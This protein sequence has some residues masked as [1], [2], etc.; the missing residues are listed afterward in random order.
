MFYAL[1]GYAPLRS[2]PIA[3]AVGAAGWTVYGLLTLFTEV[4]PVTATGIAARRRRCRGR[5]AAPRRE[6]PA[7]GRHAGRR[8]P[9]AA[10][11]GRLPRLL[12][13]LRRRRRRR[14]GD[15]HAGPGHRAR[16]GRGR[17]AG[18]V[19]HPAAAPAGGEAL[20]DHERTERP[21]L[22]LPVAV[23]ARPQRPTQGGHVTSGSSASSTPESTSSDLVVVANRL[24]VDLETL[25]DG[26][27]ALEAQPGRAGHGAGAD[28]AG[29]RG[30]LGRLAGRPDVDVEPFAEDGLLLH[31]VRLS[32]EEVRGLLRG[33]L[34]R[35]ALAALPR[36]RRH[37]RP[38]TG[39]GGAPTP[40]STSAS[41]RPS[42]RSRRPARTV[43]VQ[44]YQLQL[45][46]G[47]LRELRPDLR[48]GF[49]LHIPFPPVEL[50]R[51]LPWRTRVIG[52]PAR[53]RPGRLPHPGRR[54]QLPL[55][56]HRLAGA[57][58]D[59]DPEVVRVGER[60]VRLGAFPISIDSSPLDSLSRTDPWSSE[61][62]SRSA[63]SWATRAGSSWAS[64]GSTT[65]RASTSGCAPTRSCSRRNGSPSTTR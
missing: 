12:P 9:A 34:Q 50:F 48:I 59:R 64:T 60:R 45:V 13:A 4:G 24:P 14:T 36:R 35:H 41:P 28:A 51:Q 65:P 11:S 21:G 2:I 49:F 17:G 22:G 52:G 32:A 26:S 16:P 1:A 53:R 40:G 58:P 3:G 42:R 54:A 30:R 37:R 43:W 63:T 10:R 23:D 20:R 18:R 39:T 31:P 38:S 25:P 47:R 7:A 33:L 46:P 6:D 29:P 8:H 61:R 5:S 55:A 19:R 27:S 57:T 44:D 56:G 62:A 15:G